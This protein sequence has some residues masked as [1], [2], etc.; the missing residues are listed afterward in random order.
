MTQVPFPVPIL[1]AGWFMAL[2]LR[3]RQ[4]PQNAWLFNGMQ[5]GLVGWTVVALLCLY[6]AIHA[7][8]LWQPDMQVAGGGSDDTQLVWFVDRISG[9]MPQP[10]V[11]SFP[12]WTWRV[13]MLAWS[14]WLAASLMKWLPWAW[15][16]FSHEALYRPLPKRQM[17]KKK[18]AM[19]DGADTEVSPK[20]EE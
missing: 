10:T 7:G 13:G 3:S 19:P 11:I 12:M 15:K 6:S 5:L 2:E 14:L 18:A 8:L 20:P 16:S 9:V 4:T 17:H 1:I